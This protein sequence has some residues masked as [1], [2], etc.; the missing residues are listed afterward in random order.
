MLFFSYIVP[1]RFFFL[2]RKFYIKNLTYDIQP[3]Q[4]TAFSTVHSVHY[5]MRKDLQL[6]LY[7]KY[8]RESF[9]LFSYTGNKGSGHKRFKQRAGAAALTYSGPCPQALFGTRLLSM[10]YDSAGDFRFF[11]GDRT[12]P[13]GIT[14]FIGGMQQIGRA[15][16]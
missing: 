10:P 7:E 5:F 3:C 14:S 8:K 15:H 11:L 4:G 13:E 2:L 6:F 16:V 12:H 9:S 1:A